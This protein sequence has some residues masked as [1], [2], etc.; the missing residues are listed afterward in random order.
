MES[1]RPAAPPPV[2]H[3]HVEVGGLRIF[4][5]EAGP[6]DAPALLLLHGFPS[7][8]FQYRRL[9]EALGARWRVIAPDYPGFGHSDA[10]APASAGG[11]FTYS[12]DALADVMA[13]LCDALGLERFVAY[14]FDFGAPVGMRLAERHPG[15]IAG[16]VFQNGNV[17]EEGLSEMARG[18]VAQRPG[19]PGAE[20]AVMG[21]LTE[22]VTRSQYL[23][24][25][26]DPEA[27]APD[28]WTMDQHFLEL[29]G[30]KRIQVDL[31][32]DYHRNV[33]AYPRW[34]AWLRAHR[35]DVA[36]ALLRAGVPL[37]TAA[38]QVGYRSASALGVA[39]RRE[40]GTGA[41]ALRRG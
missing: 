9:I 39:L 35:L 10:P 17:Y 27:V 12:F 14:L 15:R 5:R 25:A 24:G 31:A 1:L 13:G 38:L 20:D 30:R 40:R 41:R 34:Q 29:P 21:I 3:R 2:R 28:G 36:A 32:L 4:Y 23:G 26:R 33:E 16:L 18:L 19:V 6:P 8:S 22:E 37:E 11:P 7:S